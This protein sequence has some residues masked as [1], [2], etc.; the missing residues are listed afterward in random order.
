MSH[1]TIRP[2][3]DEEY[4][5]FVTAVM[6]GFGADLPSEGFTEREKILLPPERTIAAF[7][8]EQIVG[9]FGGYDLAVTVPGGASMR[10]E[11]T[12][13]VTVFPTHRRLGLLREMMRRHLDNAVDAGYPIAGLWASETNIY[14]RFGYGI[15]TY[16]RHLKA[17]T[18]KVEFRDD[19][20]V[21]RVRRVSEDEAATALPEA[22]E[23][24]VSMRAGMLAR[25][26]DWWKNFVLIDEEW[27]R[28]GKTKRRYIVH[29]GPD[30]PDGY[31][32]YRSKSGESD[33]GHDNGTVHVIEVI[34]AT[35][36]ALASLW[37]FLIRVDGAPNLEAWNTP[38]DRT[39][40]SM[41]K[42]PRRLTVAKESDGLWIRILDVE[43]AL[44]GRTYEEDGS[45]TVRL[46]DPFRPQTE[47]A[48]RIAVEGG[49]CTVD[50]VEDADLEMD[51]EILGALF[52]GGAD[53]L[54]YA[55]A[56]RINGP[57]AAVDRLHRIFRTARAPWV[58][59]V[60]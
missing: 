8:G 47:G 11:G 18:P 30:G 60:F 13:I 17:H 9:T 20:T 6:E 22:Y 26:Q 52:L 56:G 37:S 24:A 35:P 14:G 29:D 31:V 1:F 36:E 40:H 27:M 54:A 55:D 19:V 25:T 43:A 12:T 32:S 3:T 10:M 34:A 39:L 41:V 23:R 44:T 4:P 38:L 48:Y 49:A 42:E 33:D 7:D 59:T 16:Y 53:A 46:T 57:A 58:D 45:V 15:A 51:I 2:V 28:S 5:A 21:G 50:R